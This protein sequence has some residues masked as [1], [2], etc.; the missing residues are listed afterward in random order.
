MYFTMSLFLWPILF[1]IVRRSYKVCVIEQLSGY[2]LSDKQA[3][4]K[5][6]ARLVR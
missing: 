4:R 1:V 3:A 5:W 2:D 6:Q